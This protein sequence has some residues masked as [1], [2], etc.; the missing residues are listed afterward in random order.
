MT[1]IQ[2]KRIEATL[3]KIINYDEG[4]MTR[5]KWL[6][7]K[8]N[9]GCNVF[10]I[11]TPKYKYSRSKYNRLSGQEQEEYDKKQQET[12]IGY[13]LREPAKYSYDITKIEFNYFKT[14]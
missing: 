9:E 7:I 1:A 5:K 8:F 2:E 10:E 14:L 3:N 11:T 13:E 4:L 12:K 6:Q